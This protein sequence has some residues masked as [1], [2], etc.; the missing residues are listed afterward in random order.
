M[1]SYRYNITPPTH[2]EAVVAAAAKPKKIGIIST[3]ID[4][5]SK[6]KGA[7]INEIV[8]VLIETFP[9]RDP[10]KMRRTCSTQTN[11]NCGSGLLC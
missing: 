1:L 10:V 2:A 7:T 5:I 8:A 11:R 6:E 3:V 4:C 9:D